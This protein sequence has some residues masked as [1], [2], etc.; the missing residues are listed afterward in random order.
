MKN[1]RVLFT[2]E[3]YTEAEDEEEAIEN[4]RDNEYAS[5]YNAI[6]IEVGGRLKFD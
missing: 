1:Y 6:E 2:P 4:V 5:L 3:Y